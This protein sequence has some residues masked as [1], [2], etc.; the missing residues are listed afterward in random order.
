M[1]LGRYQD[2]MVT[3]FECESRG[4]ASGR[5]HPERKRRICFWVQQQIL[6]R[7]RLLRMTTLA[8]TNWD[9]TRIRQ[10]RMHYTRD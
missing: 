6:R 10:G 2:Q 7:L 5:C 3:E 4:C 8:G 1:F 9:T